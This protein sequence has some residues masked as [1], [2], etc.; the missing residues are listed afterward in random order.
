MAKTKKKKFPW[1]YFLDKSSKKVVHCETRR[2]AERFCRL[3]HEHG[4][5]WNAT[6]P[7]VSDD[8]AIHSN[9]N[10]NN[11]KPICYSNMGTYDKLEWYN[12]HGTPILR[13]SSYDF[14]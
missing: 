3:M 10:N 8:G 11:N 14:T 6:H 9:Y 12:A 2:E 1:D 5:R 13:F 4:L 7:Y